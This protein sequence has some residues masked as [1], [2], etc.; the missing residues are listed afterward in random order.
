M[1]FIRKKN[2][3]SYMAKTVIT[4]SPNCS[5][6]DACNIMIKQNISCLLVTEGTKPIGIITER[7]IIRRIANN[8]DINI[9]VSHIMNHPV[10]SVYPDLSI[11]NALE[12]MHR[13]HIRHLAVVNNNDL[14]GLITQT[15][16]AEASQLILSDINI[17]QNELKELAEKDELT[18]LYNRRYLKYVFQKELFRIKRYSGLLS[19]IIF[20]IDH[21]KLANDKYGHFAGDYVLHKVSQI[22]KENTREVDTVARY[23]GEEFTVLMPAV[24]TRGA[25]VFA[26]RVRKTIS[27]TE[28]LYQ[29]NIIKITI[30]AGVCKWTKK[31]DT[32]NDIIQEADRC[33]YEA[34]KSGRNRVIVSD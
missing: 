9:N 11:S 7:N 21:F 20:D 2:V 26:E 18:K 4:V 34:K 23:G 31:F 33:L 30:S 28:F 12:K 29:D 13:H 19:F 24:G 8:K 15:D 22:I 5:L 25:K 32:M 1:K 10:I 6:I 17:R 16:L 3:G 27:E 14:V